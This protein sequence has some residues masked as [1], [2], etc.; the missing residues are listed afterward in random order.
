MRKLKIALQNRGV[1]LIGGGSATHQGAGDLAVSG[2]EAEADAV[3]I[4]LPRFV[5]A[6]RLYW[7][8]LQALL[9]RLDAEPERRMHA[10]GNPAAALPLRALLGRSVA[11]GHLRHRSALAR[12]MWNRWS[13]APIRRSTK[14]ARRRKF[15]W[16]HP[17]RWPFRARSAGTWARSGLAVGITLL[18]CAFGWFAIRTDPRCQGRPD[19]LRSTAAVRPPS[20]WPAG[21]DGTRDDRLQRRESLAS[22]RSLMTHNIQV[23]VTGAG[24]RHD[25]GRGHHHPAFLQRRD[26]G[27]G[28]GGLHGRG[29]RA[30]FSPDGCC[31]TAR[32]KSPRSCWA[33]K[34]DSF[35]PAR[36][37]A[38]AARTTRAERLRAVAHDL[39]AIAGAPP[40]MLVWAGIVEAFVSQYHQPVMPYALKIAF[41][42]LEL[43]ALTIFLLRGSGR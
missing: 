24:H 4:D 37:S 13:R 43:V 28:G 6:E 9:D 15:R 3:I 27:R 29:L 19:A 39:F 34:P 18:G 35:W 5:A 17:S 38:G 30:R 42:V 11:P 32:S 16:K 23:T 25:V 20:A 31:P 21:R 10:V 14:R 8:E 26:P 36:S 2:R 12:A 41:G 33:D 7:D 40:C 1:R 22:R